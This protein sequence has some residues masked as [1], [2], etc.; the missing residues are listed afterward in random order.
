M[1][2]QTLLALS[3]CS[4][5]SAASVN[6]G[7]SHTN[8]QDYYN[9]TIPSTSRGANYTVLFDNSTLDP[10]KKIRYPLF[11]GN[12]SQEEQYHLT[13]VGAIREEFQRI[14][15]G[16]SF[17]ILSEEARETYDFAKQL[18][19]AEYGLAMPGSQSKRVKRHSAG[20]TWQQQH[21]RRSMWNSSASMPTTLTPTPVLPSPGAAANQRDVA[22]PVRHGDSLP[23]WWPE[24]C[25]YNVSRDLR[26]LLIGPAGVLVLSQL[27]CAAVSIVDLWTQSITVGMEQGVTTIMLVALGQIL[28]LLLLIKATSIV[29]NMVSYYD[30]RSGSPLGTDAIG[31]AGARLLIV[32]VRSTLLGIRRIAVQLNAPETA[33]NIR[34]LADEAAE[35][36]VF[37][38]RTLNDERV[39]RLTQAS[40]RQA[41]HARRNRNRNTV[42]LTAEITLGENA[43]LVVNP[44]GTVDLGLRFAPQMVPITRSWLQRLGLQ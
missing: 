19:E 35:Q 2:L 31:Y 24:Y 29:L 15:A 36:V 37:V 18:L 32:A 28:R 4:I 12:G 20:R 26:T 40:M 30:V 9:I 38:S 10:D 27:V 34:V 3:L 5:S 25:Q 16:A 22:A 42:T 21:R 8:G 1:L 41:M 11:A 43:T 13:S 44:D 7:A 17:K 23:D 14:G 33:R 39:V 6:N